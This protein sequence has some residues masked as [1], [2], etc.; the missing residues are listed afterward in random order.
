M[1]TEF[2]LIEDAYKSWPANIRAEFD[3][4]RT[5]K[6]RRPAYYFSKAKKS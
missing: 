4:A 2:K 6:V 5:V 3:R 1:T